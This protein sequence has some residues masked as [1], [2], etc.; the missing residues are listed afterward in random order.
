MLL[1]IL[2]T[3]MEYVL[4]IHTIHRTE[5]CQRTAINVEVRF[6]IFYFKRW[7]FKSCSRNCYQENTNIAPAL[8]INHAQC[9]VFP[10]DDMLYFWRQ[11][12]VDNRVWHHH[13]CDVWP[14]NQSRLFFIRVLLWPIVEDVFIVC[15]RC[16][17]VKEITTDIRVTLEH[18]EHLEH[19]EI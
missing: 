6:L 7:T 8:T 10:V 13:Y 19:L 3:I 12:S 18:L 17:A 5:W 2:L 4:Y 9:D 15:R 16:V 1:I 14:R 11:S